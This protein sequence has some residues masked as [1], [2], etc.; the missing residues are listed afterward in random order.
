M[1][2]ELDPGK[3]DTKLAIIID[4]PNQSTKTASLRVNEFIQRGGGGV[5]VGGSGAI[6]SNI[7]QDTTA[8]IIDTV[9]QYGSIPIWILPGHINQI[10]EA[11]PGISGIFNYRYIMGDGG[12]D[13]DKIYPQEIRELVVK[14]LQAKKIPNIL[15]LYVL[16][17]D[18][19]ASVSKV[20]GILPLDLASSSMNRLFLKNT[21]AWLEEGIDCIYFESGSGA[22]QPLSRDTVIQTRHLID[23]LRPEASLF[24][25]GGIRSPIQAR[26]FAG[27]ADYVVVGGHFERNGV[28]EVPEFVAALRT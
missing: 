27:I 19:N 14:T 22:A 20:S 6:D 24:V 12:N 5:L 28:K 25:S 23:K 17:G 1:Q 11:T 8:A 18:P 16:C 26:L 21:G 7:F 10:L 13:F 3:I 9:T 4:P 15:T 2:K